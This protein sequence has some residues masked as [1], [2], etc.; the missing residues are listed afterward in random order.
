MKMLTPSQRNIRYLIRDLSVSLCATAFCFV[1]F[2][3]SG[4]SQSKSDHDVDVEGKLVPESSVEALP[5]MPVGINSKL[6]PYA[7]GGG[8]SSGL[9][10]QVADPNAVY[11]NNT[12]FGGYILFNGGQVNGITR[13]VADNLALIGTPPHNIGYLYYVICNGNPGPV[14]ARPK[15][16]YYLDNAGAPGAI[17]QGLNFTPV[18]VPNASCAPFTIRLPVSLQFT[19]SSN[20]MWAAMTFDNAGG[21]TATNAQMD[22]IAMAFFNPP[23][24][25]TSN[26]NFFLTSGTPGEFVT[27][28]PAGSIQTFNSTPPPDPPDNFGFELRRRVKI[29]PFTR[30]GT[31]TQ[32]PSSTVSWNVTLDTTDPGDGTQ[33]TGLTT[34]NFAL[35]LSGSATGNITSVVPNGGGNNSWTV[36]AT[37]G[38]GAGTVTLN[39]VTDSG[40]NTALANSL[41]V[42]GAPFSIGGGS[43]GGPGIVISQV[44]GG[45][46]ATSGTPTYA[47]DYVELKNIS[48]SPKSLLG[49]SLYYGS[50]TGQFAS[51]GGNAFAL[52]NVTI[53]PGGYY[54]VSLGAAGTVGA[55]LPVAADADTTN[56]T[57][58]ATNG[59][60]A[61][62]SGLPQNTCGAT[63][64]PCTLPHTQ[65]FDVA[66]YGVS[67]N[68]EGGTTVNNGVALT[69]TQGAVRKGTGC[70]DT[71]NNNADFDVVTAPVPRNSTTA[72]APCGLVTNARI[73][74]D[75]N[76]DGRTDY[77][78]LRDS[79]GPTAGGFIDWYVSLATSGAAFQQQW[80]LYDE[81]T[82][83]LA[84]ADYDND[85]K[86]DFAVWR[87]GATLS[88]FYIARSS[89]GTIVVDQL[90]LTNDDPAP[91]DYN[92]DGSADLAVV[93]NNGDN[94]SGWYYRPSP[95]ANI[96]LLTLNATG[97]EIQGDYDGDG[98]VD[99]AVFSDA[100]AQF[101]YL[102][103]SG[104]GMV[105]TAFGTST[106]M[107]APGDYDGDG[108][109]DLCVVRNVGGV[110]TWIFRRSIDGAS[111][112][113][114]WGLAAT[115]SPTPGDY[116]G[117]GKWDYAVWREGA[118]SEFF[119]MTPVTRRIYQRQWG[120]LG[121]YP[122]AFHAV[123]NSE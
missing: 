122:L 56:L 48:T 83:D 96:V 72:A 84:P 8:K 37:V 40:L 6:F 112:T 97:S 67:N 82:E 16:R 31:Q 114:T 76:A 9:V 63:A 58:S 55:A 19:V 22:L 100:T 24:A 12:G 14:S 27:S 29:A 74:L 66:S 17:I 1:T 59:K 81:N 47:K 71:D 54:L 10:P 43:G 65:I 95:G 61:L 44:Y 90:G 3:V 119:V 123:G 115:D 110:Y 102:P 52:P 42:F 35:G 49:L 34:S 11:A 98:I 106:D 109:F 4:A 25:G 32:P 73:P 30:N 101:H 77:T 38:P 36:N 15:L 117:D 92:G 87:R 57:M 121:D 50:A 120:L 41:P 28:S 26:N 116:D 69:N 45:G 46:G 103:S 99:P 60:V 79:N 62:V 23:E 18:T 75:F 64:T 108:K 88:T 107:A 80:G 105:T 86:T 5:V 94:T 20:A 113:D 7:V 51:S 53:R 78:V 13:L 104:G 118:L 39:I 68:G 93:R 21:A 85:G 2:A 70:V 89:D 91:A 33:L 111:V